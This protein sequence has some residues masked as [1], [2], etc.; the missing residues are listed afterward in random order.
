MRNRKASAS[1][2]LDRLPMRNELESLRRKDMEIDGY[3]RVD[4]ARVEVTVTINPAR[5]IAE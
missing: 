5:N 2:F 1:L 4:G 3:L